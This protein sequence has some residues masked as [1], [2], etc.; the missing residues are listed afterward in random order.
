MDL[1][2]SSHAVD[3]RQERGIRQEEIDI[4]LRFGEY[5]P[6]GRGGATIAAMTAA[7]RVKARQHLGPEYGRLTRRLDIV[8]VV[9]NGVV[10]TVYRRCR[11]LRLH[12]RNRARRCRR[13]GYS[14][15]RCRSSSHRRGTAKS[16]GISG[17][18]DE[19]T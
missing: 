1:L 19:R 6:N 13:R 12:G 17:D 10:V 8:V 9:V 5:R 3:R 18:S 2:V 4:V 14:Q 15:I 7:G 16:P 11:R